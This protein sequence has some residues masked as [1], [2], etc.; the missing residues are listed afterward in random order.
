MPLVNAL[1]VVL[2]PSAVTIYDADDLN[3]HPMVWK[4]RPVD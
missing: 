4:A 1:R 3:F 2:Q